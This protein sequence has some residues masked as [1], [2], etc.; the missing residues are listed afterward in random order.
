MKIQFINHASFIIENED[1]KLICDPWI[2]GSAFNN[3]WSLLS[4]TKMKFDEFD[5]ITHIWFSHEHPDHFSPPNLMEIPKEI[6]ENMTILFQETT[7]NK[8]LQFCKK[9]GFKKIIGLKEN[10]SLKLSQNFEILCN[11]Y[12]DGD[13]YA[14]FTVNKLKIL[15]LNDCIVN[16]EFKAKSLKNKIGEVDILFTQFGYANKIGNEKDTLL[17]KQ[18]SNEKLNRIF[19]Q[20][21]YLNPKIIVPFASFVYFSHEENKYM[22]DGINKI[23]VVYSYIKNELKTS[24]LVMY[25]NDVWEL[26][27]KID[28]TIAVNN[29]LNDYDKI[30]LSHYEISESIKKEELISNCNKF[31]ETLKKGYSDKIKIINSLKT[32]VYIS[33]YNQTYILSG[34]SG[35]IK[36][37]SNKN[38]DVKLSS[39]SLNYCFKEFWG[40][41]TLQINARFQITNQH[42]G[43]YNFGAIASSLNRKQTFPIPSKFSWYLLKIKNIFKK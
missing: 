2:K 7:D 16:T 22:N 28:S 19:Y 20:N 8:V 11:Q 23:D 4:K 6:R 38:Y 31:L 10:K 26:N 24:C 36:N 27:Q 42:S 33:D 9:I 25:P 34:K 39:D 5:T 21:K 13:S 18:A 43:F 1:I 30:N 32:I 35:L 17:R 29:Y 14:L 37:N 3:G 15:N 40:F 12:T 41:D